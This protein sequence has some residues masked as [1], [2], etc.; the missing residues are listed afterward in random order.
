MHGS[1]CGIWTCSVSITVHELL[2]SQETLPLYKKLEK[3]MEL[4][5]EFVQVSH[6]MNQAVTSVR[7]SGGGDVM[8]AELYNML[9]HIREDF[10]LKHRHC[11]AVLNSRAE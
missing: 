10:D 4:M 8:Y 7:L 6:E 2:L 9:T 3:R 11:G 1:M 5:N